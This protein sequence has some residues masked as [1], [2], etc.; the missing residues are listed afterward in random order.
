MV[1]AVPEV[2][3]A[4]KPWV[5]GSQV[6]RQGGTR[7]EPLFVFRDVCEVLGISKHRDAYAKLPEFYRR[8]R[9]LRVDGLEGDR[10]VVREMATVNEAGLWRMF[11]RSD[12][13]AAEPLIRWVTCEVLPAIRKTGRYECKSGQRGRP[14]LALDVASMFAEPKRY[15]DAQNASGLAHSTFEKRVRELR[16]AGK[17]VKLPDGRWAKNGGAS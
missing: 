10:M 12:K 2:V 17:L 11:L 6:I 8:T 16:D 3:D 4:T 15:M 7:N 9:P 14:R 1:G 13:P 5:F